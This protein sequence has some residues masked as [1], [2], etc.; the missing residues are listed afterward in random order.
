[1]IDGFRA[2]AVDFHVHKS[3]WSSGAPTPWGGPQRDCQRK[4]EP[5]VCDALRRTGRPRRRRDP[6]ARYH[7]IAAGITRQIGFRQTAAAAITEVHRQGGI[8]I[9]AHPGLETR[10]YDASALRELDGTEI[11]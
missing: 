10:G 5:L 6:H 8:A 4:G 9:A 2:L 1:M 3:L 11:C 7:L